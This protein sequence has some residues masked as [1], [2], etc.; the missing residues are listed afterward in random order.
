MSNISRI[1]SGAL[2]C[3]LATPLFAASNDPAA[4]RGLES[5][6]V[7]VSQASPLVLTD[8]DIR[9]INHYSE[10]VLLALE[11]LATG[12]ADV[13]P[14]RLRVQRMVDAGKRSGMNLLQTADYFEAYL[15][16]HSDITL[17]GALLDAD[18]YFNARSLFSATMMY[19]EKNADQDVDLAAIDEADLAA[20]SSVAQA[21]VPQAP[22][23]QSLQLSVTTLPDAVVAMPEIAPDA[24]ANV[25]AILERVRLRGEDWVITVEP[26]DSLG[27]YANALY[28]DSLLFR[29]IF[30]ANSGVLSTPNTIAVG[31]ELVLPKGQAG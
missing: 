20:I 15:A 4:P 21:R 27:Q 10:Q 13:A 26:G 31:L 30:D 5:L 23:Q 6:G 14:L 16:D 25:R 1:F 3:A 8:R 7:S 11:A 28:G 9:R 19:L 29:R 2:L 18:G 12:E 22:V 17:P 24:P